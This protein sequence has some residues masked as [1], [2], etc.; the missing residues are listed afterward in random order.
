MGR[1]PVPAAE[2]AARIFTMRLF[3]RDLAL[4]AELVADC[5]LSEAAVFRAALSELSA[6]KAGR[7]R[8][9]DSAR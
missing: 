2:R 3:P 5:G 9:R 7:A 1:P 8:L 4:L 6:S